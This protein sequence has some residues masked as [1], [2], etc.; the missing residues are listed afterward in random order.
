MTVATEGLEVILE[1]VAGARSSDRS[2]EDV[3]RRVLI[4]LF[5]RRKLK[6]LIVQLRTIRIIPVHMWYRTVIVKTSGTDTQAD[7]VVSIVGDWEMQMDYRCV[8]VDSAGLAVCT[9]TFH[10]VHIYRRRSR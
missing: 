5:C 10:L 4:R 1:L 8:D 9:R 3:S 6:R 7:E 2:L